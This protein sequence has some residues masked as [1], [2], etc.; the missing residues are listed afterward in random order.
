ME[1]CS[2]GEQKIRVLTCVGY[3]IPLTAHWACTVGG[4]SGT[5]KGKWEVPSYGDELEVVKA[6]LSV[7]NAVGLVSAC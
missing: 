2:K 3:G 6:L 4:G 7:I 5:G 1:P